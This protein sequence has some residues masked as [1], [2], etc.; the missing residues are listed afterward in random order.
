MIKRKQL[1]LAILNQGNI[2]IELSAVVHELTRQEKYAMLITYPNEKPISNNRN[3]VVQDFLSRK[4]FDYLMMIDADIIPPEKIL[5]L[6]DFDKDVITP[7]MYIYQQNIV[8]PLVM[9]M[10]REGTY[11]PKDIKGKEGLVEVD[12]T[13]TGCIVIARRVLEHP[14]MRAPFL[15][16][17][18]TDGIK[19]YGLDLAFCRRAKE[20]GFKIFVN[21]DYDCSH[22]ITIDLKSVF[23]GLEAVNDLKVENEELKSNLALKN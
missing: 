5:N 14:K 23:N 17:Y 11:T 20:A 21:L 18:D 15:N 9:S 19:R 16:E 8:C 13:G 22:Y 6:V 1:Y 7:L 3:K 4:E 2:R 10:N 12:S